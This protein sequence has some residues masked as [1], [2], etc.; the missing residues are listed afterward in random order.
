MIRYRC[1]AART[2]RYPWSS[3]RRAEPR[4]RGL[5]SR[6]RSLLMICFCARLSMRCRASEAVFVRVT[7]YR[8]IELLFEFVECHESSFS[9]ILETGAQRVHELAVAQDLECAYEPF[10]ELPTREGHFRLSSPGY[11]DHFVHVQL[12][13]KRREPE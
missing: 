10:V 11:C 4:F 7:L 1:P 5:S 2:S 3:P 12:V 6:S 8:T 13:L 9:H